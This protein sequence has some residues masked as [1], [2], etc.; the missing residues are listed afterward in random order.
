MTAFT[1]PFDPMSVIRQADIVTQFANP[2]RL[3]SDPIRRPRVARY[4]GSRM[5]LLHVSRNANTSFTLSSP[6]NG[7]VRT[8]DIVSPLPGSVGQLLEISP[9]PFTIEKVLGSFS[10][11]APIF[12][13]GYSS[14]GDIPAPADHDLVDQELPIATAVDEAYL[15]VLFQ[16]RVALAPWS[17]DRTHQTSYGNL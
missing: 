14:T 15:G 12:Y 7:A 4:G 9:L 11:G 8:V 3:P 6:V 10:H 2:S 1:P 5:I 16:D 13:L 17:L